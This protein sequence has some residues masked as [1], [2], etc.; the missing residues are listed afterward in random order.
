[1]N[2]ISITIAGVHT[3]ISTRRNLITETNTNKV[4]VINDTIKKELYI[5]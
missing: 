1:M 3:S 4:S 2:K 5:V